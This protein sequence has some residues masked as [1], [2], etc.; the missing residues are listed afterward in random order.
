[1]AIEIGRATL[2]RRAVNSR[3][4]VFLDLEKCQLLR[5]RDDIKL[6]AAHA[7]E[8]APCIGSTGKNDMRMGLS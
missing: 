5:L 8:F 3:F 2:R 7:E 6:L 1:M 4:G